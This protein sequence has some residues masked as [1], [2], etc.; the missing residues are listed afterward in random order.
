MNLKILAISYLY[1]SSDK[2][3]HGVFVHNRLKAM[4]KYTDV[5]VINPVPYFP[6]LNAVIK[7]KNILPQETI[8]GITVY[9]PRFLSFPKIFK[10]IEIFTYK[11]A[12]EKVV[13]EIGFEFNLIDLHWTFPDLPTGNYLSK[14]YKKPFNVTLRGM[15][16]FHEQDFGIRKYVVQHYLKKANHIISLSQEMAD[17]SN[18]LS[19]T[20]D[21][22]T[23]V[24]N[25]VDTGAFYYI[26]KNF[27]RDLLG[28]SKNEKIILGVGSY[29]Y[30]KGFDIV[31]KQ[32]REVQQTKGCE[33]VK[34]YILG[35]AGP[36]GNYKK[37][38]D[39]LIIKEGIANS[40]VFINSV[41]N[42][43][44]IHWYNAADVFCLSSRGEGSPNVLN[45]ALACGTPVVAA[46]VGGVSDIMN[47][48]PNLGVMVDVGDDSG[49]IKGLTNQ[50]LFPPNRE[51]IS[52]AFNV[53]N[54]DWCAQQ[55][56]EV[57]SE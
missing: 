4:S 22:T 18:Q 43:E 1:P 46:S 30:R 35:S 52:K 32:I 40:V 48:L 38:L 49:L 34:Y 20:K 55:I 33:N 14:K 12:I 15:E 50:F 7:N 2:P 36:E 37:E 3:N 8:N 19:N 31:I 56:I 54:W 26:D 24:R 51:G 53:F 16:A 29:I 11:W 39:A 23:I 13:K 27:C 5:T 25:G 28:I 57:I 17:K 41:K 21:K 42:N 47:S 9:H 44:L 10:F 6:F 45:E